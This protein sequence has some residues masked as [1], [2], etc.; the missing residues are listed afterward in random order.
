MNNEKETQKKRNK[1][2]KRTDV[3]AKTMVQV[4][5]SQSLVVAYEMSDLIF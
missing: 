4:T 1:T 2:G 3:Q 5:I